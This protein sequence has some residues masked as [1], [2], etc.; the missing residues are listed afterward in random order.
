MLRRR[1]CRRSGGNDNNNNNN[2]NN[3]AT[4]QYSVQ[5]KKLCCCWQTNKCL[6]PFQV[7]K[8]SPCISMCFSFPWQNFTI[9]LQ[10][11]NWECF[12][13]IMFENTKPGLRRAFATDVQTLIRLEKWMESQETFAHSKPSQHN[14]NMNVWKN[15]DFFSLHI[16][17]LKTKSENDTPFLTTLHQNKKSPI[18]TSKSQLSSGLSSMMPLT[19]CCHQIVSHNCTKEQ[20][21]QKQQPTSVLPR[22]DDRIEDYKLILQLMQETSPVT[23][24]VYTKDYS[25]SAHMI[26]QTIS[27]LQKLIPAFYVEMLLLYN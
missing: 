13:I 3:V 24:A 14:L 4:K 23:T 6:S 15:S 16:L 7:L 21:R 18:E 1:W 8:L 25:W 9:L 20:Q 5:S 27:T 12:G 2:N 10:Q 11:R 17:I 19:R 22:P 26:N